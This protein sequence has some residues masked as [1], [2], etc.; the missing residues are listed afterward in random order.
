[1]TALAAP[2][3]GLA[4]RSQQAVQGANRAV[5]T[6]FVQQRGKDCR[7]R[8]I[9]KALAVEHTEQTFLFGDGEGQRW[10]RSRRYAL[11]R[12]DLAALGAITVHESRIERESPAGRLHADMGRELRDGEHHSSS[13]VSSAVGSPR[14]TH[15]FFGR[16]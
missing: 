3:A 16:R 14:A 1:M 6:P 9:G 8:R 7:R 10:P 15:S 5:I 4:L 13:I 11:R 12:R 2:L